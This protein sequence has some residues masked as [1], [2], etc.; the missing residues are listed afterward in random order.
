MSTAKD[1][2]AEQV[3]A[4]KKS[5]Q[6]SKAFVLV[7]Y[8][9][10]TVEQDTKLRSEFR[11]NNV[12]YQV[13]KNRLIK[14]ALNELGFNEFDNYLEKTT[15]IAFANG[16]ELVAA[17]VV[18]DNAKTVKVLKAKC[19]LLDGKFID[20]NVVT[21]IANIPSKDILLCQL[22]GVLQ[23]GISGLARAISEIAK[24]KEN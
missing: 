5:V 6:E 24:N 20:A 22:C 17:K 16:D 2:K 21:Q 14:R 1:L 15:A 8:E 23:S 10:I 11:A 9:G 4:I 12:K 19:G 7:E 13:L 3:E 18:T